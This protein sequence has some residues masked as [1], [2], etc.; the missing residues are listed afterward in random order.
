[1]T[2][3]EH[4]DPHTQKWAARFCL[5][6]YLNEC[7]V[8]EAAVEIYKLKDEDLDGEVALMF[9]ARLRK[10]NSDMARELVLLPRR[11]ARAAPT[12]LVVLPRRQ[13]D[14]QVVVEK[15]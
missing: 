13:E 9:A 1:M 11:P 6:L 12:H 2:H 5:S 3:R 14:G 15:I 4:F 8:K 7:N 10:R